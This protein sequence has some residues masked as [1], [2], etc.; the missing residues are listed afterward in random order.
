MNEYEIS[1]FIGGCILIVGIMLYVLSWVIQWAWAWVDDTKA[2]DENWISSKCKSSKWKYPVYNA[3]GEGLA[4]AI[5]ENAK[6]FGFA[7][8]KANKNKAVTNLKEGV[9]YVYSHSD[10]ASSRYCLYV[11]ISMLSPIVAVLSFKVYNIVMALMIIVM[12]AYLARFAKRSKKLFDKH[13]KD[14]GAHKE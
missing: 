11:F 2:S 14:K 7:K 4:S 3:F 13:V 9:D 8:D 1:F 12:V 5:K 6:P 10:L